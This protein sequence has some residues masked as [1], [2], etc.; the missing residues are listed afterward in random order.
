MRW[1]YAIGLVS[2]SISIF[3]CASRKV[4]VNKTQVETKIDSVSVKKKDSVSVQQN[5]ISIKEDI[6]EIEVVPID[7]TKPIIIGD[8][9]YYNATIRIKKTKREIVD[10]SKTTVSKSSEDKVSVKKDI[11]SK[12]FAK[13]VDKKSNYFIFLWLL[14]IPLFAWLVKKFILK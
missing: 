10:T 5:A 13:K 1:L 7:T 2:I 12:T 11:K 3:S 4:S 14:L 8:K 6:D 9:K